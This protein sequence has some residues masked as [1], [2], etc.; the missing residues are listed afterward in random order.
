MHVSLSMLSG[1]AGIDRE[2]LHFQL[3]LVRIHVEYHQH[4]IRPDII[5]FKILT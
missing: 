3:E 5:A 2:K 4:E 1:L